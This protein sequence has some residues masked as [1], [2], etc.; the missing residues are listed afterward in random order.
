[1]S[2]KSIH[3]SRESALFY[4]VNFCLNLEESNTVVLLILSPGLVLSIDI[5]LRGGGKKLVTWVKKKQTKNKKNPQCFVPLSV[6]IRNSRE[7][8]S[9]TSQARPPCTLEKITLLHLVRESK[10][11]LLESSICKKKH[12][13]HIQ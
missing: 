7:L 13:A 1:M 2:E 12:Y 9:T 5:P 8:G 6:L 10:E 11:V 3:R 4:A